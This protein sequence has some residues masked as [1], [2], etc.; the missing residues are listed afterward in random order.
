AV[1]FVSLAR[2]FTRRA[3]HAACTFMPGDHATCTRTRRALHAACTFMP[4]AA[5]DMYPHA[6]GVFIRHAH[7]RAGRRSPCAPK[8]ITR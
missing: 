1:A 8:S 2:A 5:C 7:A 6:P 3:L 4:G